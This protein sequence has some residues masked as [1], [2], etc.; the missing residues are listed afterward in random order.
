M[1]DHFCSEVTRTRQ[2]KHLAHSVVRSGLFFFTLNREN[3][4]VQSQVLRGTSTVCPAV[5][6]GR[7]E[8]MESLLLLLVIK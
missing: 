2:N 3:L 4:K 6:D 1:M 5:Y 8:K 7:F